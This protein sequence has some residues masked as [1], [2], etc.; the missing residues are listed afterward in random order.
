[1][2]LQS[3]AKARTLAFIEINEL[4]RNGRIRFPEIV[5]VIAKKYDFLSYPAKLDD[6]DFEK[7]V[8]F[9]S[10]RFGEVV[11][12][13]FVIYSGLIYSETLSSTS[14]SRDFLLEILKWGAE[15]FGLTYKLGMIHKWAYVSQVVFTT[16]FPLLAGLS[17]PLDN[18]GRKIT[19]VIEGYFGEPLVYEPSYVKV[20]HDPNAR[21]NSIAGFT[22]QHRVNNRF[23]EN[24]YFSEA[25]LPTD[26]HIKFLQELETEVSEIC[27]R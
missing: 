9:S 25:P 23:S 10:G 3:I 5:P 4:N 7:G 16:D 12:D 21:N 1:M 2:H 24:K 6:F 15:E 22:I 20:G 13:S 27:R 18:L 26:L 8:T 17:N 11:I 19:G 14:D